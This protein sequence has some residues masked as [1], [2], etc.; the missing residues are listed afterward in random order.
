MTTSLQQEYVQPPDGRA[1]SMNNVVECKA[2]PD[3]SFDSVRPIHFERTHA[4]QRRT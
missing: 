1:A 4:P 3:S 2:W